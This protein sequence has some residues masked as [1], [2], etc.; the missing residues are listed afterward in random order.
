VNNTEVEQ[1]RLYNDLDLIINIQKQAPPLS[2]SSQ[3][4]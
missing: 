1:V 2:M 4:C 3:L